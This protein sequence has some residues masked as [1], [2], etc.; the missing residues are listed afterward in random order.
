MGLRGRVDS[1]TERQIH[2][3]A[4]DDSD[5]KRQLFVDVFINSLLIARVR[6]S[7]W[8]EDLR[9][10]GWGDGRH[11]FYFDPSPYLQAGKNIVQIRHSATGF[12]LESGMATLIGLHECSFDGLD[13]T[14][15]Q[16]LLALS[17][18]RWRGSEPDEDLTWGEIFTGHS[19]IAALRQ[20]YD[21]Q[22][23]HHICEVGPGYG[24]LL[25]TILE[26]RLP[27]RKYT[28]VELSIDRVAKLQARF[29]HDAVEFVQGD[30]NTVKLPEKA[31]LVICSATFQHLFPDFSRALRNLLDH[32]TKDRCWLAIDFPQADDAMIDR[33]QAF[34]HAK[35]AFVRRYSADEIR[36]LFSLC[37][38]PELSFDSIVLGRA[39]FGEVRRIFAF[40][41]VA[42]GRV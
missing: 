14:A 38:I 1:L 37:G 36:Q 34:E 21:F 7:A 32:N 42:R 16:R 29:P 22:P 31:D 20:H 19:F 6:A 33:G 5:L 35:H 27:F 13:E 2:G 12:Q 23:E 39:R 41:E 40:G 18:E 11:A 24:R 8:R 10:E 9:R 3:W 30:V 28:G 17:Q 25:K 4:A 15:A 26:Q